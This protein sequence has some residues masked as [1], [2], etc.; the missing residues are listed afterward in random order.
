MERSEAAA[1]QRP[2]LAY[3]VEKLGLRVA[4]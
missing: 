3:F 1:R 2:L 4:D